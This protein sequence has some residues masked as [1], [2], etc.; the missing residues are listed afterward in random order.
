[1]TLDAREGLVLKTLEKLSKENTILIGRY[2]V[3]AYVPPRF[4][5]DCDLVV[6]GSSINIESQLRH[7]GFDKSEEGDV[8][9]GNYVRYASSETKVSF[10][11]LVNSV[12]DRD[13]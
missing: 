9:Y 5:I 13:T 3:N 12:V 7:E 10:D 1:M 6:L 4:S 8:S 2:A 11:L